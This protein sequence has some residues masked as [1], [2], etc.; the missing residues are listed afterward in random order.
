MENGCDWIADSKQIKN[1]TE[2]QIFLSQFLDYEGEEEY[3]ST[4]INSKGV[5]IVVINDYNNIF[6]PVLTVN[7]AGFEFKSIGE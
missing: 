3:R 7:L 1:N 4:K 6:Y 5:Q 2:E